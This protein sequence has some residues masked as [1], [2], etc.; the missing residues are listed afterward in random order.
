MDYGFLN[1]GPFGRILQYPLL[2]Q[3]YFKERDNAI[4]L[5]LL[6]V[7]SGGQSSNSSTSHPSW[8]LIFILQSEKISMTNSSFGS[9]LL[10]IMVFSLMS[11]VKE[12]VLTE[13]Q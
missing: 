3:I 8:F 12:I 6:Y 13:V 9:E 2:L 1:H 4:D 11:G 7:V 10:S 5:V